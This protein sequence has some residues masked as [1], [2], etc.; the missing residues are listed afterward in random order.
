MW[1]TACV[2]SGMSLSA[3]PQV[4]RLRRAVLQIPPKP[5]V[6]PGLPLYKSRHSLTPSESTLTQVLIPLHF[7]SFISN[8]YKKPG[9]GT[10]SSSPK[11]WQLVTPSPQFV[12][13]LTPQFVIPSEAR[14]LL[15]LSFRRYLITSLRHWPL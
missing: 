10:P 11:V 12:I 8:T 14:N 15:F 7:I 3:R 1:Y 13:T 2:S 9:G 4:M 5:S 6:P